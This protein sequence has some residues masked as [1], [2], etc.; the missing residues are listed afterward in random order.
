MEVAE[1]VG[2]GY[3]FMICQYATIWARRHQGD[4]GDA[5][6]ILSTALAT[7]EKN[8]NLPASMGCR[9]QGARLYAEALDYQ[10]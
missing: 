5:R 2:D 4:G 10:G 1:T 3:T 6:G 9:L 8:R 7:G